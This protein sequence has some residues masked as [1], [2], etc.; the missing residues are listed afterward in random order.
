MK[1]LVMAHTGATM[2]VFN[3]TKKRVD[4]FPTE[5]VE[6]QML[7]NLRNIKL[8]MFL[9]SGPKE[10]LQIPLFGTCNGRV[11]K[12]TI[13]IITVSTN[14]MRLQALST[15]LYKFTIRTF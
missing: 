4:C 7:S 12:E 13:I 14:T 11:L 15:F 10:K 1:V 9:I 8:F 3:K 2:E 6:T 5:T